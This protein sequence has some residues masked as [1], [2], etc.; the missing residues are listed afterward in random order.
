M[1]RA[2]GHSVVTRRTTGTLIGDTKLIAFGDNR[3]DLVTAA[4]TALLAFIDNTQWHLFDKGDI[5][6]TIATKLDKV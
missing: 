4:V 1:D 6:L 2:A 3:F 5:K